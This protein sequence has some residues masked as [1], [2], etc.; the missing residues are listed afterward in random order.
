MTVIK[1]EFLNSE[2]W[3]NIT[4]TQVPFGTVVPKYLWGICEPQG[5]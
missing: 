4:L 3:Y 2:H 1:T 5:W